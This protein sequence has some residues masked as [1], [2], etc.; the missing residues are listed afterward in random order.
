MEE[1]KINSNSLVSVLRNMLKDGNND[2]L[3]NFF[4]HACWNKDLSICQACIDAGIS[5]NIKDNLYGNPLLTE[6]AKDQ[7][8]TVEVAEFLINNGADINCTD[9]CNATPLIMACKS[10]NFKLAKYLINKGAI[11]SD[12]DYG[13]ALSQA[14]KVNNL[15]LVAFL[16]DSGASVDDNNAF[17]LAVDNGY[18]EIVELLLNRG[19]N[20][21]FKT[22]SIPAKIPI[23]TAIEKGY[24]D[25]VKLLLKFGVDPNL[26]DKYGKYL[27]HIAVSKENK[28]IVRVLLEY[29]VNVNANL[30]EKYY[31]KKY[32]GSLTAMDIAIFLQNADIQEL[33]STHGGKPSDKNQR[34]KALTGIDV[35][36]I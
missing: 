25:I 8:L 18:L 29:N 1:R 15:N 31:I 22:P 26:C 11:F 20:P 33:L 27:I 7:R 6:A 4:I 3:Q 32:K 17:Y 13:T 10:N 30:K 28:D 36:S 9:I 2:S 24:T 21:N 5:P 12:S 14:V 16:L 23:V 35:S 19:A 34:I